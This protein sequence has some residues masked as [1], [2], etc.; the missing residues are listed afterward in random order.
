MPNKL[1]TIP[2]L[3][4]NQ[5]LAAENPA[6]VFAKLGRELPM[7]LL[8]ANPFLLSTALIDPSL[9]DTVNS[10]D[11]RRWRT[12]EFVRRLRPEQTAHILQVATVA[13]EHLSGEPMIAL[14]PKEAPHEQFSF[15]PNTDP[16]NLGLLARRNIDTLRMRATIDTAQA[17]LEHIVY[18]AAVLL[19]GRGIIQAAVADVKETPEQ[20]YFDI[21]EKMTHI[22]EAVTGVTV[23]AYI[24]QAPR[25]DLQTS[26]LIKPTAYGI[27]PTEP[28]G[29]ATIVAN[30]VFGKA[31]EW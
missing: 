4:V 28:F 8:D 17:G 21:P 22:A 31:S 27:S 30:T 1:E 19:S 25:N 18:G 26:E 5:Q 20:T 15:M 24:A 6:E 9:Q 29:N 2:T 13:L 23:I 14:Q 11:A 10:L 12:S 3:H 16:A 7:V